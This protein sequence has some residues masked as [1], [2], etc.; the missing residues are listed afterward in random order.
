MALIWKPLRCPHCLQPMDKR[1]LKRHGS[2]QA[3]LK[4]KPFPCPHCEKGIILPENADTP[5]AI[6]IFVAVI[7]APLF[8]LWQIEPIDPRHVFAIGVLV[9]LGGLAWQ[10]LEK[11]TLPK[12][13][14]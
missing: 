12:Q 13:Q 10:K 14:D 2:L 9:L 6:G 4:R 3:F 7:L 5:V 8:Q 1:L 11:S